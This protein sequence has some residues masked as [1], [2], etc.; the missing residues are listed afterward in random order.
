MSHHPENPRRHN[1]GVGIVAQNGQIRVMA[2]GLGGNRGEGIS[3]NGNTYSTSWYLMSP[4]EFLKAIPNHYEPAEVD[5][6]IIVDMR[7]ALEAKRGLA[8]REPLCNPRLGNG[9][10]DRVREL[11]HLEN[12][13][14]RRAFAAGDG[15][16]RM[17]AALAAI[18]IHGD[19]N[20]GPLDYVGPIGFAAWWS[21]HGAS[22]GILRC[23]PTPRIEW[24]EQPAVRPPFGTS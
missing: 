17:L 4:D 9:E 16:Q 11:P 19:A 20:P 10:I 5:G 22:I 7:A 14:V 18:S 15:T 8:L 3:A 1:P 21:Q 12:S 6:C 24:C 2:F 23:E 13:I